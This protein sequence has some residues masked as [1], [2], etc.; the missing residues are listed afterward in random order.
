MTASLLLGK[1]ARLERVTSGKFLSPFWH[2]SRDATSSVIAALPSLVSPVLEAAC[3]R[4][5]EFSQ[6]CLTINNQ[7]MGPDKATSTYEGLAKELKAL[8]DSGNEL[9]QANIRLKA[10]VAGLEQELEDLKVCH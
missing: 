5:N 3:S 9:R 7:D 10:E 2:E 1:N 4:H 8:A 6:L